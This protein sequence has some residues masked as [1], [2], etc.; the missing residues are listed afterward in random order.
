MILQY[1]ILIN[2]Y[3]FQD[4]YESIMDNSLSEEEDNF[5][6][7]ITGFHNNR[8]AVSDL[9]NIYQS[10][11]YN[12]PRIAKYLDEQT[13]PSSLR[14]AHPKDNFT[15]LE[16]NGTKK[17]PSLSYPSV[18]HTQVTTSPIKQPPPSSIAI[19]KP[20]PENKAVQTLLQTSDLPVTKTDIPPDMAGLKFQRRAT[21]TFTS[22]PSHSISNRVESYI[23]S[24]PDYPNLN[25]PRYLR[26]YVSSRGSRRN[27]ILGSSSYSSFPSSFFSR[28][29]RERILPRSKR[30]L[31]APRPCFCSSSYDY[32]K[33]P[34]KY[35]QSQH[36]ENTN[37]SL[38]SEESSFTGYELPETD[39]RRLTKKRTPRRIRKKYCTCNLDS[40]SNEDDT[41]TIL[42]LCENNFYSRD[43]YRKQILT[44]KQ[45]I[46]ENQPGSRRNGYVIE[47]D[48]G[49]GETLRSLTSNGGLLNDYQNEK[50]KQGSLRYSKSDFSDYK[51][52]LDDTPEL[53]NRSTDATSQKFTLPAEYCRNDN[54]DADERL[55]ERLMLLE[56]KSKLEKS[57][58]ELENYHRNYEKKINGDQDIKNYIEPS[59][60]NYQAPYS[61]SSSLKK[62]LSNYENLETADNSQKQMQQSDKRRPQQL[63]DDRPEDYTEFDGNSDVSR[64]KIYSTPI[65]Y[66]AHK[67]Y[68]SGDRTEENRMTPVIESENGRDKVLHNSNAIDSKNGETNYVLSSKNI[69]SHMKIHPQSNSINSNSYES[70]ENKNDDNEFKIS[71]IDENESNYDEHL[72]SDA[73]NSLP[74]LKTVSQELK[75]MPSNDTYRRDKNTE[76]PQPATT[77]PK[78]L[79]Y[80]SNEDSRSF[81]AAS[82]TQTRH[83]GI[84]MTKNNDDLPHDK[85][86]LSRPRTENDEFRDK[87]LLKPD[88]SAES[89]NSPTQQSEKDAPIMETEHDM[90]SSSINDQEPTSDPAN[91]DSNYIQSDNDNSKLDQDQNGGVKESNTMQEQ[92]DNTFADLNS[93][94]TVA[95]K[96]NEENNSGP[97]ENVNTEGYYYPTEGENESQNPNQNNDDNASNYVYGDYQG[98]SGSNIYAGDQGSVQ[99][100]QQF[101]DP[102][103]YTG[104]YYYQNNNENYDVNSE[105]NVNYQQEPNNYMAESNQMYDYQ[106]PQY[107]MDPNNPYAQQ[108]YYNNENWD[109]QNVQY[110]EEYQNQQPDQTESSVANYDASLQRNYDDSNVPDN[111]QYNES[112]SEENRPEQ[113]NSNY[114]QERNYELQREGEDQTRQYYE[115]TKEEVNSTQGNQLPQQFNTSEIEATKELDVSVQDISPVE[116]TD[117]TN[118]INTPDP[119][120]SIDQ[121]ARQSNQTDQDV[122]GSSEHLSADS[123]MNNNANE[124]DDVKNTAAHSLSDNSKHL[125]ISDAEEHK[126]N[127]N[128]S[129]TEDSK[130]AETKSNESHKGAGKIASD[131]PKSTPSKKG[132][133]SQE[134][135]SKESKAKNTSKKESDDKKGTAQ[136]V[137]KAGSRFK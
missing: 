47:D 31:T 117:K 34:F 133:G 125:N 135:S 66:A 11:N 106:Q 2:V 103:E 6:N 119:S 87:V 43:H 17:I 48:N 73:T 57:S 52:S 69:N 84:H 50:I 99:N 39:Y 123:A 83:T 118:D 13:F 96:Q 98:D 92:N 110:G 42:N 20:A 90:K 3:L 30:N 131:H 71:K 5:R 77:N 113:S 122:K 23:R 111:Y 62:D 93:S 35:P 37:V 76:Q 88:E 4:H 89:G 53:G 114:D 64:D 27:G 86:S 132:H 79:G 38:S 59:S 67:S 24:K 80:D 116:P 105:M 74:M 46:K 94:V 45:P 95:D 120:L 100:P 107:G 28:D 137:K 41:D 21:S 16:S 109:Q 127:V 115:S 61:A 129:D 49:N 44:R 12:Q 68:Y 121:P 134:Q 1:K 15:E 60:S 33:I 9:S 82:D 72:S 70:T 56:A 81:S 29:E 32:L 65:N 10:D 78:S 130:K 18:L 75:I 97:V 104:Q 136:T 36:Y 25:K 63:G 22:L 85:S 40:V 26:G 102:N 101:Q 8:M 126:R 7:Y 108:Y 112:Q 58:N 55:T 128:S 91:N 19:R 14:L 54:D 51:N 124:S